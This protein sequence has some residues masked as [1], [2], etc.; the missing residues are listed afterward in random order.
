VAG[1]VKVLDDSARKVFTAKADG[2]ILEFAHKQ[3]DAAF[4]K[5]IKHYGS[6]NSNRIQV[7]RSQIASID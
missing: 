6:G 1:P 4:W 2:A 7:R 3:P 5:G